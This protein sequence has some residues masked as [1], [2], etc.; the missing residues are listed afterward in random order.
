MVVVICGAVV[1]SSFIVET[2]VVATCVDVGFCV[3]DVTKAVV[4]I[5]D[6]VVV[7]VVVFAVVC[8]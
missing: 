1:I 4:V 6:V 5:R 2:L 8:N 3:V 7:V